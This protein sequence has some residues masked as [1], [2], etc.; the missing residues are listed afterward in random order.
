M[1]LK[2]ME[3]KIGIFLWT[4][5]ALLLM[6][7]AHA[8][9]LG[10]K[11]DNFQLSD[12]TGTVHSLRAYSGKIVALVFWSFKCPVALIYDDRM[13]E[14]KDKYG[15]RGVV[16]LGI[17]SAANE[18]ASDIRA[19]IENLKITIPIL[20]DSEGNLAE[21]IGAT[22]TPGVFV[23]DE[24]MILRYRGALD[25]NRKTGEKGRVAYVDDAVDALLAGRN[26]ST[27]ETRPFG[28][29]IRRQWIKE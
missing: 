12:T 23:L 26:V 10:S 25:N 21:R 3:R 2:D 13:N 4:C 6:P 29:S 19:N 14:L 27:P 11:I 17:D 16:V 1:E 24:N 9:D 15:N 18:T 8:A 22:Q 28:C 20:L 5:M 7:F